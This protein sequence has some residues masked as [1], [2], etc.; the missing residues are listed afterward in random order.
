MN[1]TTKVEYSRIKLFEIHIEK[2]KKTF[3]PLARV[4]VFF[5]ASKELDVLFFLSKFFKHREKPIT[6]QLK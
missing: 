1:K 6:I 5:S 4:I 2:T 3:F